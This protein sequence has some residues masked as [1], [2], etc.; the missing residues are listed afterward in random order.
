MACSAKSA[1][2][3]DCFNGGDHMHLSV[4]RW[5]DDWIEWEDLGVQA[6]GRPSVTTWNQN[7]IDVFVMSAESRAVLHLAFDGAAQ[8]PVEDLGGVFGS[9][10]ECVTP[11]VGIIHCF[12]VGEGSYLY[13]NSFYRKQWTD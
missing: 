4:Q 12:A 11:V 13:R 9:A 5:K 3:F 7:R 10:P 1:G 2:H 6:T 8:R